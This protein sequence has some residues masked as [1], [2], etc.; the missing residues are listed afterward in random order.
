[1]Q[2]VQTWDNIGILVGIDFP[3]LTLLD[4]EVSSAWIEQRFHPDGF[5]WRIVKPI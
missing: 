2:V 4:T 5:D 3:L 1:V